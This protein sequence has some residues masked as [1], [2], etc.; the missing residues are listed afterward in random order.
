MKLLHIAII[1]I[2]S[3]VCLLIILGSL[4]FFVY[5]M[6]NIPFYMPVGARGISGA[7]GPPGPPGPPGPQGASIRGPPGP[8]GPPGPEG[9]PG[10]VG[11]M[12]P[13][14]RNGSN[15]L[16]GK[17]VVVNAQ[18]HLVAR[19]ENGEEC[20]I[21]PR[22]DEFREM[23]IKSIPMFK[24]DGT[25]GSGIEVIE[26]S[27]APNGSPS[28]EMSHLVAS[29]I[30]NAK[31]KSYSHHQKSDFGDGCSSGYEVPPSLMTGDVGKSG[32]NDSL[33]SMLSQFT[34]RLY[35]D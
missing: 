2:V 24:K 17:T 7:A 9:R 27:P 15:G 28:I 30:R 5:Q 11:P 14:G 25:I 21:E 26:S 12:G 29:A 18:G 16:N 22:S 13:P 8:M 35:S 19:N 6:S 32:E 1:V 4:S 34:K 20:R 10:A 23:E 31:R 3:V 33:K